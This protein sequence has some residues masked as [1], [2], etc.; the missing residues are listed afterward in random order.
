M[1][2]VRDFN[3]AALSPYGTP[4][5]LVNWETSPFSTN[6]VWQFVILLPRWLVTD[7][8]KEPICTA[9]DERLL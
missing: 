2:R 1:S 9:R 4:Q 3:P 6:R 7:K 8:G 5:L